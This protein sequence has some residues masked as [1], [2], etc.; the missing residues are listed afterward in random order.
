MLAPLPNTTN[1]VTEFV[2]ETTGNLAIGQKTR[3]E[4]LKKS[5]TQLARQPEGNN[6]LQTFPQFY[7]FKI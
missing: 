2:E 7:G 6:L 3:A 4:D 5:A 1:W